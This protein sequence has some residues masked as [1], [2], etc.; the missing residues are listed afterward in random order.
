MGCEARS[1]LL[2]KGG[3]PV[4][5]AWSSKPSAAVGRSQKSTAW[6]WSWFT[7]HSPRPLNST[8]TVWNLTFKMTVRKWI[9]PCCY[10]MRN[11]WGVLF[12]RDVACVEFLRNTIWSDW[13]QGFT[14]FYIPRA[15]YCCL[16]SSCTYWHGVYAW[17]D[18]RTQSWIDRQIDGQI[19]RLIDGY[20]QIL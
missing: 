7:I 14:M 2:W 19:H 9:W 3:D 6:G 5:I 11:Y 10:S 1:G 12:S 16:L 20:W 18:R 17:M 4:D 8:W 15:V 13:N